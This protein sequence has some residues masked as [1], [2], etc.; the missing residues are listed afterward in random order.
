MRR[1][2]R[3]IALQVLFQREYAPDLDVHKSLQ[4]L[5]EIS[6]F[7]GGSLEYAQALCTGLFAKQS[8][9]DARIQ[10]VNSKWSLD[11]MAMVDLNILRLACFELTEFTGEVPPRVAIDEAI[12][13]A[14]KYGANES[15]GFINGILNEIL[16][17]L[18]SV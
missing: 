12:E 1:K 15:P 7:P 11:R 6:E 4:L 13:M 10:A 8:V 5:S 18:S 9:I 17:S 16:K 14:K 2:A 3:E